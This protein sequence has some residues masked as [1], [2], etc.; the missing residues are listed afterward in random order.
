MVYSIVKPSAAPKVSLGH[1]EPV[2]G[3]LLLAAHGKIGIQNFITSSTI[4]TPVMPG[5][6]TSCCPMKKNSSNNYYVYF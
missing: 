4:V 2:A 5:S 6:A 1:K 3:A